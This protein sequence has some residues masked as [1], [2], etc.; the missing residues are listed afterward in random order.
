MD[1]AA[2]LGFE[3]VFLVQTWPAIV[4]DHRPFIDRGIPA[5]DLIDLDY[6]FWHTTQDTLDKVSAESL[7]RVGRVLQILLVQ[8]EVIERKK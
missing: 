7:E 4:D 8:K 1:I 6:P 2:S 5:V 3:D